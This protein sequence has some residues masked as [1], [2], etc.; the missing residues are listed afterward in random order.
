MISQPGTPGSAV[1]PVN[2]TGVGQMVIDLK[3]PNGSIGLCTGTLINPRTVIFA[4]H[5]VNESPTGATMNP[6]NY[7]TGQG[8]LPIGFGFEANNNTGIAN[9]YY[10]G[11]NQYRNNKANVFY[12]V[13]QVTY[14]PDSLGS[15]GANFVGG[16]G[17]SALF[18]LPDQDKNWG[19]A[20][21]GLSVDT[22]RVTLS[23]SADTTFARDD[24][25]NQAYRGS[26][27]MRF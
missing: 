12:N 23:A 2:I 4:A 3:T 22:G 21:L 9:W 16:I 6:W 1:D 20:S 19:E 7:G 11:A 5:C 25:R 17:P 24:V 14:N 27:K 18:A 8:P 10:A 26:V 15:F 13:G